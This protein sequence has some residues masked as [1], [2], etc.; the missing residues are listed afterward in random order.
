MF[1]I[2]YRI[3][4][5]EASLIAVKAETRQEAINKF[6]VDKAGCFHSENGSVY[7]DEVINV[8]ALKAIE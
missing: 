8:N 1:V 6:F 7:I 3:R 4:D 2:K 5:L